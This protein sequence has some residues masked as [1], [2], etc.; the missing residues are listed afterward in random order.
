MLRARAGVF[1]HVNGFVQTS[2][3]NFVRSTYKIKMID[4]KKVSVFGYPYE[5]LFLVFDVIVFDILL[6]M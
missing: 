6:L 3:F 4:E 5:T 1:C 2:V